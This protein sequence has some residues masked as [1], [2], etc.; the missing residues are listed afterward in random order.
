M[1]VVAG[2]IPDSLATAAVWNPGPGWGTSTL[3]LQFKKAALAWTGNSALAVFRRLSNNP[4]MGDD[5]L[6]YGEWTPAGFGALT[7][8]GSVA[9][10]GP[11]LAPHG[12]ATMLTV[13]APFNQHS[14]LQYEAGMFGP[15][16]AIPAG[17]P[18]T[19][20]FGPSASTL[21][22]FGIAGVYTAY[23][24]ADEKTYMCVK[25]GPGS[26]WSPSQMV[27]SS[28]V[29][30]TL[31]PSMV[32]NTDDDL[33]IFYIRKSDGHI[34]TV[35]LIT[36]QNGWELESD[37]HPNAISGNA[38][39]AVGLPGGDALVAWRGFDTQGIYFS[40]R[41]GGVWSDPVTVDVPALPSSPPVVLTG[42]DGA[43]AEILYTAG[44]KLQWARV[45]GTSVTPGEDP[46][47]TNVTSIAGLIVPGL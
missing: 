33:E 27:P 5:E 40:R 19:T 41:T 8:M 6:Y 13:L 34:C 21:V 45:T 16:A 37:I 28:A 39:A 42:L 15:S 25:T 38:P 18:G 4:P 23:S 24:G 2:G 3:N 10:D 14:F 46:K 29:V 9:I 1:L 31:A 30:N 11:A 12:V 7:S 43:D 36:P 35:K 47:V 20:A 17:L 22:P 26:I 32:V 44:A